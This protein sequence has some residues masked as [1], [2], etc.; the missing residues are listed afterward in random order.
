MKKKDLR[1]KALIKKRVF[2]AFGVF[3]AFFGLLIARLAYIMIYRHS[4]FSAM[5]NE[6]WTSEVKIDARR[7][8]ILDRNGAELAVSANVYRVDFDLN[9]IRKYMN[10]GNAIYKTNED[11]A[12]ALSQATGVQSDE[13]VKKLETKLS[14]GKD[15]GS[16]IMVRRIEKEQADKVTDLKVNGVIV[17]PDTKR[18]YP[19]GN[20]LAHVL[21]STNIDGKGLTGVELQYDSSLSGVQ[22]RKI[23]ELDSNGQDFPYTIS[24]YTSPVN[25]SDLELTIDQNI[26]SFAEQAAE[27]AY[28]DNKAKA[29]SVLVMDPKTG[30]I[31]AM[32]NKPDFDPNS[33]YSGYQTFDGATDPDKVQKMWRNRLVNDTFEPGSIFK[34]ITGITAMEENLVNENTTFNCNGSLMVAGKK[35]NCWQT[36]GHG[37]ETFPQI[38]PNSCNVAFMELGQMIGK[39]RLTESIHKF[40]FGSVSGVDLPGESTGIVKN[41]NNI[42]PTDLATIAFGQTNTVNSV[43]YMTAF[44]SIANGGTLIQPHVMKEISHTED[45]GTTVIDNTFNPTTKTVASSDNTAKL[46]QYLEKVV[47]SGSGTGT[48]IEGY[49]IGGKTGT[50]QK[51]DPQNGTYGAGK[52]I[53]SFVG[54]APV[55]DPKV[56]VMITVDE[57]SNNG[58]YYAAQVAVPYAKQLFLSIFNY[59]DSKFSQDSSNSIVKEVTIPEVRGMKIDDAKKIL[60]DLKLNATVEGSGSTIESV[61]PYPGYTVKE[62]ETITLGTEGQNDNSVIMPDVT[63]FTFDDANIELG[64]L[65][66]TATSSG[67]GK[68]TEQSI[69][70]GVLINKGTTV[71]LDLGTDYKD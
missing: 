27:Q 16:A 44:N 49:H 46:R 69:P 63:G 9:A 3:I 58:Q 34:V 66:I 8:K 23:A 6:Q 12:K 38:F 70:E 26:Q 71:K 7:G 39:E 67:D 10:T 41:A 62:G 4:D 40:G 37:L 1:D 32:V 47:T 57:P 35:I 19:N 48:F 15:A 51:V 5:A 17:S 14:S 50:A 65:G 54:M 52:Y 36:S 25:G 42:S 30:E 61:E 60:S 45:N 29:A 33:P 11:L 21:G 24:Q 20:F 64:K 43:Q 56:T 53:S 31:L 55:D 68:V 2:I 59:M 28:T 22:G 18:Y 13:I